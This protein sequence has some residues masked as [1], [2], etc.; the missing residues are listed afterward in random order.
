MRSSALAILLAL[1]ACRCPEPERPEVRVVHVRSSCLPGPRPE[2]L[3][4]FEPAPREECKGW[5]ACY[6]SQP[7][8][9]L[10]DYLTALERYA[11][12]VE[13]LCGDAAQPETQP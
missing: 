13:T 1:V 10:L 6:A 7:A 2:P 8:A 9:V 4:S 11:R 5:A 12:S 3:G